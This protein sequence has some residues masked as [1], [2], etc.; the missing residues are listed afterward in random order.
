MKRV[1][2]KQLDADL[3]HA[4]S[5]CGFIRYVAHQVAATAVETVARSLGF[6]VSHATQIPGVRKHADMIVWGLFD[7]F[8]ATAIDVSVR[9]PFAK[10]LGKKLQPMQ[11]LFQPEASK[12]KKYKDAYAN[13]ARGFMPFVVSSY[14]FFGDSAKEVINALARRYALKNYVPLPTAKRRVSDFISCSILRQV[15]QNSVGAQAKVNVAVG[16][17]P[18]VGAAPIAP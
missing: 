17:V 4:T 14:G 7:D 11:H 13:M 18:N 8:P 10:P 15:A 5:G 6:A 2:G 12:R 9:N 16:V 3:F 1:C